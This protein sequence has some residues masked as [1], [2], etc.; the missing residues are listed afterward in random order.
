M[1]GEYIQEAKIYSDA[2]ETEVFGTVEDL[3]RGCKYDAAEIAALKAPIGT[4][5][6]SNEI[7]RLIAISI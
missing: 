3:L 7:L 2:L 1:R 5:A 6:T 4:S